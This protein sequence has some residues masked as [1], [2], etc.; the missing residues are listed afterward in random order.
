MEAAVAAFCHHTLDLLSSEKYV[1][2]NNALFLAPV[3]TNIFPDYTLKVG[4]PMDLG[5]ARAKLDAGSYGA[6]DG[7]FADDVRLVFDN[8]VAYNSKVKER[9]WIASNAKQLKRIFEKTWVSAHSAALVTSSSSPSSASSGSA[10]SCPA[11]A[12]AAAADAAAEASVLVS[13]FMSRE[14]ATALLDEFVSVGGGGQQQQLLRARCLASVKALKKQR[15]S[16][17][18]R[19]PVDT[20]VFQ[21]Y[22]AKIPHPM[23]LST[24]ENE[25]SAAAA[26]AKSAQSSAH[27]RLQTPTGGAESP[28][29]VA[30][31]RLGDFA[32]LVR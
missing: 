5:T 7:A 11:D 1:H 2:L 3:D 31:R 24:L 8:A 23:S 32:R 18:F 15:I 10:A 28:Q 16:E 25:L 27:H 22:T 14:A 13:L 17:L 9:K 12:V 26:A 29:A 6:D 19:Q 30:M 21:D 4:T 20:N